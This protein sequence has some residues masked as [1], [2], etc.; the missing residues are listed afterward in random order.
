MAIAGSTAVSG[1]SGQDTYVNSGQRRQLV[2][3]DGGQSDYCGRAVAIP[4]LPELFV[5]GIDD[6]LPS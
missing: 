5:I 2:A 3:G 1:A 6:A 4:L